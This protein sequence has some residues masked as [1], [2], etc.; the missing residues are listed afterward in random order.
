[1]TRSDKITE[2]LKYASPRLGYIEHCMEKQAL[3]P[4][5]L[6]AAGRAA[7]KSG[8][9][10]NMKRLRGV[11]TDSK[12]NLLSE[13]RVARNAANRY[14]KINEANNYYDVSDLGT[15]FHA[16]MRG[17]G[18]AGSDHLAKLKPRFYN[19][20]NVAAYAKANK[21]SVD[22]MWAAV[23][24]QAYRSNK[25]HSL[26]KGFVPAES[27]ASIKGLQGWDPK[28]FIT[29][30][31]RAASQYKT[32]RAADYINNEFAK[33]KAN[34]VAQQRAKDLGISVKELFVRKVHQASTAGSSSTKV[35]NSLNWLEEMYPKQFK[36][37]LNNSSAKNLANT[38][39]DDVAKASVLDSAG[40]WIAKH[41]VA[42]LLGTAGGT[43]AIAGGIGYGMGNSSGQKEGAEAAAQIFALQ[44]ALMQQRLQQANSSIGSR[45]MNL[46]G[47]GALNDLIG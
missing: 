46:F 29:G 16:H 34:P 15:N 22:D 37:Y 38:A 5:L 17:Q 42:A 7:S 41:P 28:R 23:T 2:F 24:A 4:Q 44:Q 18:L 26:F 25:G 8:R 43:G 32:S 39:A 1:M 10:G 12:G 35:K 47:A 9:L 21:L 13:S 20:P 3:S 31:D 45:F 14:K 27:T 30:Y 11:V 6:V 36:T 19:D 33:F 40:N